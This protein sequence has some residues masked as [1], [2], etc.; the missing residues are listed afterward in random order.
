MDAST[1]SGGGNRTVHVTPNNHGTSTPT[2]TTSNM[3]ALE[4]EHDDD[5]AFK[6][7]KS[8]IDNVRASAS[9]SASTGTGT[10][11]VY[12]LV[13]GEEEEEEGFE[14]EL[15][16]GFASSSGGDG[17]TPI[18]TTTTR[19]DP[20]GA[21]CRCVLSDS[22][23]T[24]LLVLALALVFVPIAYFGYAGGDHSHNHP[25]R[26]PEQDFTS[27]ED[28]IPTGSYGAIQRSQVALHNDTSDCWTI[29]YEG[30]Y[31]MTEYAMVHPGGSRWIYGV[32]GINGTN[33]FT[34]H[35]RVRMLRT[36]QTYYL[37]PLDLSS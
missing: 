10:S 30:V 16:L 5:P 11:R 3:T 9:A 6:D 12:S 34:Q 21:M 8:T 37:G 33:D 17:G 32:C 18:A 24:V 36:A 28:V 23:W 15:E 35:H 1:H 31:D 2:T 20:E 25:H 22:L 27:Y 7:T 13:H 26:G 14:D 19:R 29:F 4:I